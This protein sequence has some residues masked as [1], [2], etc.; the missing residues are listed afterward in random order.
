MLRK[1]LIA[2]GALALVVTPAIALADDASN[3]KYPPGKMTP[4]K[5]LTPTAT[6]WE[7]GSVVVVTVKVNPAGTPGFPSPALIT[8]CA[9]V[10]GCK[11]AT[12]KATTGGLFAAKLKFPLQSTV[13]GPVKVSLQITAASNGYRTVL[14]NFVVTA[15]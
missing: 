13:V 10:T 6:L 12:L 7:G 8:V 14:K 5:M 9:G 4:L 15:A 2:A 1:S 11:F 3:L